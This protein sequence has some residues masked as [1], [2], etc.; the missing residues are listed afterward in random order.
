VYPIL[1]L[2]VETTSE[3]FL[4]CLPDYAIYPSGAVAPMLLGRICR[5]WRNIACGIPRLWATLMIHHQFGARKKNQLL[6][7]EWLRRARTAPL[8]LHL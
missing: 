5:Q 8:S 2:P 4:H 1:T 3:I 7:R 6:L